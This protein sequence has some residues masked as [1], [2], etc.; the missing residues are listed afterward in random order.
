YFN[1][2]T[3]ATAELWKVC[4]LWTPRDGSVESTAV[5]SELRLGFGLS[6]SSNRAQRFSQ[7]WLHVVA[8]RFD[9]EERPHFEAMLADPLTHPATRDWIEHR[10]QLVWNRCATPGRHLNFV[11]GA[12]EAVI[13][14]NAP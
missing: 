1:Q 12:Q 11:A 6:V 14:W 5:I 9:A 13:C 8:K 4:L 2:F 3:L 7:A 10:K